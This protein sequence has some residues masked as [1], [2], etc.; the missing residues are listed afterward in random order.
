MASSTFAFRRDKPVCTPLLTSPNVTWWFLG[1]TME[2]AL[3]D[4][5]KEEVQEF[6]FAQSPS[7]ALDDVECSS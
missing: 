4:L 3:G 6:L 2:D 7:G 1:D 5:K